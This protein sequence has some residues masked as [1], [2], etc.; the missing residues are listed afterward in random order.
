M[1]RQYFIIIVFA[2][3]FL[4]VNHATV[5][6]QNNSLSNRDSLLTQCKK[7]YNENLFGKAVEVYKD[8]D[9]TTL[10]AEELY[11]LGLS[12]SNLRR[13]IDASQYF[14]KA[15]TLA[16]D[17]NGYRLQYARVLSQI[18]KTNEAVS[19][20]NEI[21]S[22]DSNNVTALY[23]LGRLYFDTKEYFKAIRIFDRLV[24]LNNNDF[25]SSYFLG[26]AMQLSSNPKFAEQ[27]VSNL[28]HA[29]AINPEYVPAITLLASSKYGLKQFEEANVLYGIAIRLRLNVAEYYFCS[30]LCFEKLSQHRDAADFYSKAV[31]LDTT[32]ANYFDHLGYANFNLG[33]YDSAVIAY[34]KAA[35]IDENPTY[36]VNLGITYAKMDSVDQSLKSFQKALA[37]MPFDKIGYLYNQIAAVHYLKKNWKEARDAYQSALVYDPGNSNAQYFLAVVFDK[38]IDAKKAIPAYEKFI[39]LAADDSGQQSKKEFAVKRV[40]EL[41][42]RM[43]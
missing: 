37:S 34:K 6:A 31:S 25:L 20:Y 3:L 15:V 7:F 2:A 29:V 32:I 40:K 23:E 33:K 9:I 10:S 39:E 21:I 16:P 14:E 35:A 8:V 12:L 13:T 1:K 28:E 42:R 4:M 11:Y 17:H 22:R 5:S 27:S 36:F 19:N 30:G 38:L 18:G 24:N 43:R 41:Q 26:Y